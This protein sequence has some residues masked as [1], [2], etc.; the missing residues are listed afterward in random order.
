MK[1]RYKIL[2]GLVVIIAGAITALALTLTYTADCEPVPAV[3]DGR[4]T[5]QAVM[6]RCYGSTD[7]LT[8]ET[9][10]KPVPE[11]D[12]LLIRVKAAAVNPLDY[13]Y[14][15]GS[16]YLMR[17]MSGIGRPKDVRTGV[18]FAGVVEAVGGEVTRF[19]VGDAVFGGASGA[20]A[21][22][23][24]IREDAGVALKP[25]TVSFEAAASMAI[26]AIT[27]LQAL[28]D[29]GEVI[30][31]DRVLIN[32]ASGGVGSFAVQMAKSMG[33]TV[34][35]VCS[36]SNVPLVK[37]LGADAVIDYKQE[38]YTTRPERYDA[39]IDMVGNHSPSKNHSLLEEG[40]RY[41]LVGGPKGDWIAPLKRPLQ[42]M[43]TSNFVDEKLVT[44]LATTNSDDM[45]VL[46]DMLAHQDIEPTLDRTYALSEIA[47]AIQYSESQRAR[48]KIIIDVDL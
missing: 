4:E 37:E 12:E 41:V 3:A 16:P 13:H 25:D 9:V 21:E 28:R 30:A 14:M 40:G 31:E 17:L 5:M 33:A 26:A 19:R 10:E 39:I 23:L 48:G 24:T 18:D 35:G 7:A 8:L 6:S 36:T 38:D 43:W 44:M 45:S 42:A 15:R 29:H 34:T 1:L 11:P 20:F 46:A 27:A 32:G 22:Y 2:L 47:D